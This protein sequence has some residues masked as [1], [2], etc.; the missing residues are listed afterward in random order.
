[1]PHPASLLAAGL[2]LLGGCRPATLESADREVYATLDGGR[3]CVPEVAGSLTLDGTEARAQRARDQMGATRAVAERITLAQALRLAAQASR[4]LREERE[5]VYL[6]ALDLS[7]VRHEFSANPF[8]AGGGAIDAVDG[9]TSVRGNVDA[10]FT[11]V[12]ERGGSVALT[13]ASSFLE[14][15]TGNPLGVAQSILALDLVLPL[16]RGSGIVARERLTQAE[17]DTIYAL[18]SYAFF[19]Q[20]FTVEVATAYYRT[21]QTRDVW[22]NEERSWQSLLSFEQ[23]Q[24]AHGREGA[25]RIPEFQVEQ[26]RQDTLRADDR[27]QRA[28]VAYEN[29]LDDLK[30]LLGLPVQAA[31]EP[32]EDDLALLTARGPLAAPYDEAEAQALAKD[33]RLDLRNAR[34]QVEDA[35]RRAEVA[36][37]GLG[38]QVDLAL[39]AALTTPSTQP[40]D[41]REASRRLTLGLDVDLPIDRIP[42]RNAWRASLVQAVR[43]WR[44][45]EALEDGVVRDVRAA[46]RRL[47]EAERSYAIQLEGVRL[48]ERRVE[49]TRLL[50]EAGQAQTRDVLDAQDDFV[51]AQNALT[52]A[53]VDHAVAR[54]ALERA[55]GTLRVEPE[56]GFRELPPLGAAAPASPPPPPPP[57]L[58]AVPPVPE[59][60]LPAGPK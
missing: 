55:V 18:R 33:R 12:L 28:R 9:G 23:R 4:E 30:L 10:G 29:A 13:L 26:T 47:A 14:N 5:E 38:P 51:Q 16:A 48:A 2:L 50:L 17:R 25:G 45:L 59:P 3:S 32:A 11:K 15:L 34:D 49:S 24:R 8:L 21:L 42:E 1:L 35:R 60:A 46:L 53:L 6:A 54:L 40:L 7:S 37:D 56:G 57:A 36:R 44:G 52:N 20:G 41:L 58:P 22:E 27:R 39:G 19:Q 31:I 43:A